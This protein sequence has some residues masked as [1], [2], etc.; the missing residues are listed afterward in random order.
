VRD[1]LRYVVV[2][3][4]DNFGSA[5]QS[6]IEAICAQSGTVAVRRNNGFTAEDSTYAGLNVQFRNPQ[7]D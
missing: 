4:D 3:D 2:L 5:A 6:V 7:G 1:A